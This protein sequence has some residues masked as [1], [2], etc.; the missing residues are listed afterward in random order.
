MDRNRAPVRVGMLGLGTVGAGVADVLQGKDSSLGRRLGRPIVL[1]KVL[2]RDLNKTRA[3]PSRL[4]TASAAE[5][6]DSPD[7]DLVVEVLGGVDPAFDYVR[8]SLENG[9]HVITANKELMA[10]HGLELLRVSQEHG[11]DLFFE[12]SVGGGIPLIG[13]FRQD[14]AA[15]EITEIHAIING[16][17]NYI[18]T[19][20]TEDGASFDQALE[21]ATAK[22]YA[23]PD[24]TN[25]VDGHDSAYKLAILASLAFGGP[26]PPEAVYKEGIRHLSPVDFDYA[27]ELGYTIKLL[28]TSKRDAAGVE[29]R[30]HPALVT[31][32]YLLSQVSGVEN[33]VRI[34]G[35]LLGHA[36]FAGRG[37]GPGPTSSAIV[38]DL[39]DLVH[40]INSGAH[41]RVPARFDENLVIKPMSQVFSR[42][43]F[44]VWVADR[45][46]VLARI[47]QV[48]AT[49][50]ISIAA[51]VQKE[52]DPSSGTAEI[53]ILT[54]AAREADMQAAVAGIAGL[55]VVDRVATLLRVEDLTDQD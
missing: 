52:A 49:T 9:K 39:I 41:A 27:R 30:V 43:Y 37:A 40:N 29:V 54:H 4:L 11:C 23:E 17:T 46:G 25:D 34:K 22:G 44:R 31:R 16:T 12:A 8:R 51:L 18:L 6:I 33:A 7:I 5:V 21:E 14:L 38:A 53:V 50:G 26:V 48:C 10:H 32:D 45:A 28:A 24:P 42:Y 47:G 2:V 19:R 13:P 55:E 20:M 35:D 15:N 3:V 36:L 1:G